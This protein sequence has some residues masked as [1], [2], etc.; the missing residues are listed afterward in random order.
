MS[1]SPVT[2]T[3]RLTTSPFFTV[4]GVSPITT[5]A[6]SGGG[7]GSVLGLIVN[8]LLALAVASALAVAVMVTCCSS[9]GSAFTE[10]MFSALISTRSGWL[11]VQT[12]VVSSEPVTVT[13]RL[14]VVVSSSTAGV[15]PIEILTVSLPPSGFLSHAA[16]PKTSKA[17]KANVSAHL[18]KFFSFI[19]LLLIF[20]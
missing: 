7:V 19:F 3:V 10:S 6:S 11:I 16:T 13:V 9:S 20:L 1:S 4:A 18:N 2:V 12:K 15:S 14:T 5:F 8:I 17:A